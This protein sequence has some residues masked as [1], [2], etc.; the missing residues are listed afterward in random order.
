MGLRSSGG[1]G[2]VGGRRWGQ[3]GGSERW[4]MSG[5]AVH[6][7]QCAITLVFKTNGVGRKGS[8]R[9]YD[10]HACT[11]DDALDTSLHLLCLL[12]G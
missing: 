11:R 4:E 9:R 1:L 8:P 2:W 6:Y 3:D 7:N 10:V 12:S 5:A